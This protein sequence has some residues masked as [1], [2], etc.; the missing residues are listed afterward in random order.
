MNALAPFS[1]SLPAEAPADL[2]TVARGL[3]EPQLQLL[4]QL[5]EAGVA[6]AVALK[7]QATGQSEVSVTGGDIGL[8]YSRVSRA[9]RLSLAL[10]SSLVADLQKMRAA[11]A[12]QTI[13]DEDDRNTLGADL[14]CV[15]KA[16]VERIIERCV[17]AAQED[18]ETVDRLVR[19]AGERLDDFDRYDDLLSRP[20]S[21]IVEVICRDLGV[22]LDWNGL[23]QEGWARREI[24]SGAPGAPLKA[25]GLAPVPRPPDSP[26]IPA[27][28][29]LDQRWLDLLLGGQGREGFSQRHRRRKPQ[30]PPGL[31][32]RTP[33]PDPGP[34]A[35]SSAP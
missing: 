3:I 9:V 17:E 18:A 2:D 4:A 33:D 14:D 10:Q 19:E 27:V 23:A 11:W 25:L 34:P 8:A 16:R 20:F 30:P 7:D 1:Q 5:A 12:E 29:E 28:P 26:P 21:E 13:Q 22:S 31:R 15:R 24:D 35:P 6:I 32:S